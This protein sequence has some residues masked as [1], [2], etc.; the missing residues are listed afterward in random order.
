MK[1]K[2]RVSEA[3]V[4]A[5]LKTSIRIIAKNG[6][7]SYKNIYKSDKVKSSRTFVGKFKNEQFVNNS[8]SLVLKQMFDDKKL[9][10]FLSQ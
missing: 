5:R 8:L 10:F 4:Q 9:W 1:Y 2:N 3:K 6:K 7:K